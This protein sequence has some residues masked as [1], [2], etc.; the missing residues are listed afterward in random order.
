MKINI[1]HRGQEWGERERERMN[2]WSRECRGRYGDWISTRDESQR[3]KPNSMVL[4][5][6]L[7]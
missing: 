7:T 6:G 5:V 2:Q 1:T 3:I 4:S